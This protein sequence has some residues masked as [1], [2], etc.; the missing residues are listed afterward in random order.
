MITEPEVKTIEALRGAD[1]KQK[2]KDL[3]GVDAKSNNRPYLV[4]KIIEALKVKASEA[5]AKTRSENS[6]KG[7]KRTTN[8][9][10]NANAAK[11]QAIRDSRLPPT[12]LEREHDGKSI[13]VKVLEDGFEYRGKTYNSLSAIANEATGTTWNGFLFFRLVPYAK[14]AKKAA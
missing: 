6:S 12:S 8:A 3:F 2:Y 11:N 5:E 10:G 7:F 1:L 4:R 13:R 14:R 9:G